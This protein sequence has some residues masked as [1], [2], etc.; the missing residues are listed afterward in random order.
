MLWSEFSPYVLPYVSG[1]PDPLIAHHVRL[2]AIDFCR[3]TSCYQASLDP[4]AS[5]G[6]VLVEIEA[7]TGLQIIKIKAVAVNGKDYPLVD[8]AGG[9]KLARANSPQDFCFTQDNQILQVYPAP[10]A[11]VTVV[12]DAILAPTLTATGLI[13]AVAN[14]YMQ[15]MAMGAIASLQRVPNQPFTDLNS[16]ALMQAQYQARVSTTAAKVARGLM[17]GKMRAHTTFL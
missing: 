16:S 2:A 6:T 17:G 7:D 3:R 14:A 13:N 1:A 4:I 10:A 12:L 5:D 11:G 9:L 8:S 15:D